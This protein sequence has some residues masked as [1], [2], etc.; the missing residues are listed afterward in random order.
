M[1]LVDV[2]G[3][4]A[5]VVDRLK[6]LDVPVRGVNVAESAA[7]RERF[8]RLRD[9]GWFKGR[10]WFASQEVS[11]PD[12]PALISELTQVGYR[13]ESTGKIRVDSKEQMKRDG[14]SSPDLA[15]AFLLTFAG[16]TKSASKKTRKQLNYDLSWVV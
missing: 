2:I 15:D 6:E 10:E 3:L 7:S 8:M 9:E 13:V 12:A 11:M 14:R 16:P 5:G 4:G 1:V